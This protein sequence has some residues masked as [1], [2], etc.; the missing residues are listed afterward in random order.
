WSGWSIWCLLL[1]PLAWVAGKAV[2]EWRHNP[3]WVF[4]KI[5]LLM[6]AV[7]VV[8]IGGQAL[9]LAWLVAAATGQWS[10][11]PVVRAS[12]GMGLWAAA[13]G[14]TSLAVNSRKAA[15]PQETSGSDS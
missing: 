9:L 10:S 15:E 1:P 13:C 4:V 12:I 14:L 3:Y 5:G 8:A 11:G 2:V 6:T 7:A